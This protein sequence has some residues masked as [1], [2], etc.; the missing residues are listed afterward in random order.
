MARVTP[1]KPDPW[2]PPLYRKI[3][4]FFG[5]MMAGY[6]TVVFHGSPHRKRGRVRYAATRRHL[7][8]EVIHVQRIW[9]VRMTT[10]ERWII[11]LALPLGVLAFL[12]DVGAINLGG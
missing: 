7:R 12:H 3:G 9:K 11:R 5:L 10:A 2:P 6:E 4:F 8:E 1:P